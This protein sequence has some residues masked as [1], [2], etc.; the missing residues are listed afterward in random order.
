MRVGGHLTELPD[1]HADEIGTIATVSDGALH[2][3]SRVVTELH[4]TGR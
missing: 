3:S 4:S 2:R 1:L